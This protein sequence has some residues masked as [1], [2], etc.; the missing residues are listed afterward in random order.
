VSR[1][2]KKQLANQAAGLCEK[3]PAAAAP[4]G[5]GQLYRYCLWH[6]LQS[7]EAA[8]KRSGAKRRW[9]AAASYYFAARPFNP[10]TPALSPGGGE[11]VKAGRGDA[12]PTGTGREA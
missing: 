10:V 12:R 8:R 9:R 3:C 1:Q 6:T 2:R 11:G 5:N 4:K 7:R